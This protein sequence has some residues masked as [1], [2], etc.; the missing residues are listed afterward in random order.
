MGSSSESSEPRPPLGKR[1]F[2][3]PRGDGNENVKNNNRCTVGKTTT[4]H[5]HRTFL[6]ISLPF[7]HNY[8]VKLPNF[9]FMEDVKKRRR[10][11]ILFLNL[12]MFLKNSTPAAFA[13]IW[14]SMWAG[15]IAIRPKERKF[16]FE[17]TFLLPSC[18]PIVKSLLTEL[19]TV[20]SGKP[21]MTI[22]VSSLPRV[23]LQVP[24]SF[25]FL[26]TWD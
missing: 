13:Y 25:V 11:F 3:I 2:T 23:F 24:E 19:R 1:D 20:L 5:V 9:T 15:I 10:N 21:E 16:I 22:D 26:V 18:P 17:A 4:L 12:N 8:D 14:Q 7:L 6:H